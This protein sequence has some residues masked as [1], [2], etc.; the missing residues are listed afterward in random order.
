VPEWLAA[1]STRK[2]F[3]TFIGRNRPGV[4]GD[5]AVIDRELE[6]YKALRATI[7]AR[8][9]ARVWMFM[10]GMVSWSA[11]VIAVAS[12]ASLPVA[13]LLPLL[14]LAAVYESVYAL[15]TGIERVGRYIQ[16]FYEGE[17]NGSPSRNWEH[18]AMAF[19]RIAAPSGSDPLFSGFFFVATVFNF[20]PAVLAD[21]QLV[22]T[23]WIVLGVAHAI[24][25]VRV[26]VGRRHS[27]RQRATDLA[28]F[29][30]LRG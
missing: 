25:I 22:S 14:A 16:V 7:L 26:A 24:L 6:E 23:E 20:V 3:E 17:A 29:E 9:T 15:H 11:L 4:E 12:L 8:G 2:V 28:H 19:G 27:A 10:A 21:P 13:T 1:R 30:K 18:T 5:L